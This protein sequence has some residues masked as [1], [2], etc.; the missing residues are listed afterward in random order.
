MP[1]AHYPPGPKGK[2]IVGLLPAFR[3]DPLALF[4][5][6]GRNYEAHRLLGEE[7]FAQA[8]SEGRTMTLEQA[9]AYALERLGNAI[10]G[11]KP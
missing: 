3:R 7:E 2:P 10:E 6:I 8:W 9:I 11:G 1:T 4:M 5:E